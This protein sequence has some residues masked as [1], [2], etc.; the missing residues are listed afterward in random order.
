MPEL[1]CRKTIAGKPCGKLCKSLQG[2]KQHM[3]GAHGGWDDEDIRQVAGGEPVDDV[4]TRM[5]RFADA[6]PGDD[7][8]ATEQKP[9]EPSAEQTAQ[10]TAAP[11]EKRIKA[12]PKKLKKVLGDI[13]AKILEHSGI[14]LD[15]DDRDALEEAS[16]MM[17]S[18]FGFEFAIP[19][20]KFTIQSRFIAVLWV[21]GVAG[22][23]WFKHKMPDVWRLMSTETAKAKSDNGTKAKT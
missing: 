14:E 12:T 8:K 4:R 15:S 22:L 20:S 19:E 1:I 3:T 5:E 13:P 11:T 23:V 16:E 17:A 18:I 10:A 7:V 6:L 9:A 21:V 2:W